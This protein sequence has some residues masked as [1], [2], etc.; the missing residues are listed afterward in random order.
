ML[1]PVL[2]VSCLSDKLLHQRPLLN[3]LWPLEAQRFGS[4][5][6]DDPL[7]PVLD[8]LEGDVLGGIAGA[9]QQHVLSANSVASRKS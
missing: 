8:A 1:T 9:H 7:G 4:P 6:A 2:E 3:G 5:G